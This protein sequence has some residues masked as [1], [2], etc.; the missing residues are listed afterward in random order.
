MQALDDW[1]PDQRFVRSLVLFG[2]LSAAQ[3]LA[4][5]NKLVRP[6][7]LPNQRSS[8]TS[9][10]VIF[11]KERWPSMALRLSEAD[12]WESHMAKKRR[13][14]LAHVAS[15]HHLD[16]DLGSQILAFIKEEGL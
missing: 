3:T 10:S 11:V 9:D 8:M 13:L 16:K 15:E 2:P 14:Y 12:M 1:K 4:G 5:L 7:L 6:V